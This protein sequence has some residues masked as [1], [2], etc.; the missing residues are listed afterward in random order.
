MALFKLLNVWR[1]TTNIIASNK[2]F[3]GSTRDNPTMQTITTILTTAESKCLRTFIERFGTTNNAKT[4]ETTIN[5]KD[6]FLSF[7]KFIYK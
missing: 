4:T 5:A 7:N 2:A 1:A 6:T 3:T